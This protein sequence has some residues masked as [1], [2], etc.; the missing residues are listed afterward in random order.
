[1]NL[2]RIPEQLG[3]I[4]RLARLRQGLTQADIARQLGMSTQA[5]SKLESQAGQAS[6]DRIHRL[7]LLLGLDTGLMP[8]Q[9]RAGRD[10]GKPAAG[11]SYA[12]TSAGYPVE[13][14]VSFFFDI[15]HNSAI[16]NDPFDLRPAEYQHLQ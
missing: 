1:M 15:P 3:T 12:V 9:A 8:R 14:I 7:C 10:G 6:F 13:T 5:V 2:I 11:G 16:R 4:L